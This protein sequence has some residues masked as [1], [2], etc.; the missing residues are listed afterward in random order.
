MGCSMQHKDLALLE[1]LFTDAY[2]FFGRC[3]EGL[4]DQHGHMSRMDDLNRCYD[5]RKDE[6]G[7]NILI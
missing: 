1:Y 7:A 4:M 5:K 2:P 6:F 3:R